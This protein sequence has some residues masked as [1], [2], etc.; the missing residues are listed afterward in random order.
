MAAPTSDTPSPIRFMLLV[1]LHLSD[2]THTG[3]HKALEWAVAT[4]NTEQPDFLAV[5][6]D[7]TTFGTHTSTAHFL[8]ALERIEVPIYFT[9]GNAELRNRDGLA[10]LGSRLSPANRQLQHDNLSVLLPDTSTGTLPPAERQWLE[11]TALAHAA[12]RRILI[13]HFPLDTLASESAEWLSQWL[14]HWQV[15]LVVA[16]HRHLQRRRRLGTTTEI[17]C[18][19]MDPDKAIGDM[20]GLSLIA[21]AQPNEWSERFLPWSPT[22]ELL[23]ADLPQGI[24]PVGWSIHGDPVEATRETREFGLSCLELRPKAMEFSRPALHTELAQLRDGGPRYLSYH[25]SN[26]AWDETT[27]SFTGEEQVRQGLQLA[28][29]A[30]VDSLTMHVPR[31]RAELMEKNGNPTE[32]YAAFQDLYARLFGDAVRAGV[33]LSI[34]NIHNPANTPIDSPAL[35]F[36]TQI[37]EYLR[38][39]DALQK[40]IP[41]A[42]ANTIG[43]HFD[44]GH[45]RNNGGDLDN[46]QPLGDWY[47]RVGHRILGYHIHQV[48]QNPET[49]KLANHLTIANLFG[50]RISYAGFLWAWSTRQIN[51]APLFVEVRQAAGRRETATRLKNLFDNT[52]HIHPATDLSD[53]AL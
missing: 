37:D 1:D 40:A 17:V 51:R 8:A 48:N 6:G 18:R 25:L 53:R 31:A 13:T 49:G 14:A 39:L 35:E 43:A 12:T 45:A 27:G 19:G 2:L 36:A 38:W 21:S 44:I 10:L 24:H 11:H 22:L 41:N 50:P 20:P 29:D 42:P 28:L 47:A 30:D 32:L 23:P 5:A 16:G 34:E 15:E 9:P 4:I 3:A 7:A 33:R 52:D 26:L 46:M